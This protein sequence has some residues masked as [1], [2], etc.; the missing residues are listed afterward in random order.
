M[1]AVDERSLGLY[2]WL[3]YDLTS[4]DTAHVKMGH[5]HRLEFYMAFNREDLVAGSGDLPELL[6]VE[7]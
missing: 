1:Y 4:R 2:L 6:L 5:V 3:L 7:S